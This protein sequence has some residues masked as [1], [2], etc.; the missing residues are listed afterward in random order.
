[1][2]K[3]FFL[4]LFLFL[5]ACSTANPLSDFRFQAV[6]A[7]PYVIASWHKIASPGETLKVYIEGDGNAF[8]SRGQPTDNPTPKNT[9]WR[10]VAAG[11]PSPNVAYV[12]RPCQ[13]LQAG[14]CSQKDWTSGRFSPDVVDSMSYVIQ[15]LQKKARAKQVVLIG[16]SGGAQIAGLTAVHQPDRVAQIIT[17]AGVLDPDAWTTYHGDAPLSDSL[18]LKNYFPVFQTIP[19]H[20]YVGGRDSVVPPV[21]TQE[22]IKD[23]SLITFVPRATHNKGWNSII[24]DIYEVR[25]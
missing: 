3:I 21:L 15:G 16:Y 2:K 7:S 5:G 4:I 18:N 6:P 25:K 9:F 10:Q 1:M 19:Q 8:D 14:G 22:F 20:H 11:D 24:D 12:G 23:E 17:V 13:Y